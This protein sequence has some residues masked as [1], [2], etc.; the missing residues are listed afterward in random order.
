[1]AQFAAMLTPLRIAVVLTVLALGWRM[2]HV[3]EWPFPYATAVQYDCALSA[4]AIWP[5]A[6]PAA[7]TGEKAIWFDTVG[8]DHVIGPLLL[9][10]LAVGCYCIAGEEIPW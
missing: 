6:A 9:P 3:T 5:A 4:R 10:G 2:V 7:R 1:M 8:F